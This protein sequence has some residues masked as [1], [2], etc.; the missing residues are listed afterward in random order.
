M[1]FHCGLPGHGSKECKRPRSPT[2]EDELRREAAAK[3]ARR[4]SP[5]EGPQGGPSAMGAALVAPRQVQPPPPPPPRTSTA[6]ATLP[7]W[8]PLPAPRL[9]VRPDTEM[10]T[11]E[12]C[13]VRRSRSMADLEAR[14]QHAMVAYAGGA[15]RDV[16]PRFVLEALEVRLGITAE[17]V[18]VHCYRPE[19]FLVVFTRQDHRNRVGQRPEIEYKGVR[20]FFRQWNRQSQAV[21]AVMKFKVLLE[22]EGIPP[23]TWEREVVEDLL[24]TA[25]IVDTVAPETSSRTD[26]SS[27][28]VSAWTAEPEKIPTRRWLAIPEPAEHSFEPQMLHYKVL[29]HLDSVTDFSQAEEPWFLGGSSGSGQ[30]GLPEQDKD[31]GSGASSRSFDW[32]FGVRDN[33][34]G[35]SMRQNGTQGGRNHA[36]GE[37][38]FQVNQDWRIPPMEA[39][40]TSGL[41]GP[42]SRVQDRLSVRQSAFD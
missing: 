30:S 16:S 39:R 21:H 41:E 40:A 4:G 36:G 31:F 19:D 27:F 37:R 42:V 3:V 22:L 11:G 28:K 33:R 38:Q 34:G 13:V 15:R 7:V 8:P 17:F 32:Q 9:Q 12:L 10:E 25:C 26:L 2:P 23:H 14:L 24:G 35:Q 1:C 5:R 6:A 29:I 18:S 20:L